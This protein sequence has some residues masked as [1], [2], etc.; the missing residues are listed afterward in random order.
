M[1]RVN[2][3]GVNHGKG[4]RVPFR[5]AEEAVAGRAGGVVYDRHPLADKAVEQRRFP[6]IGSAYKRNNWFHEDIVL[7]YL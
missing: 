5:I 7:Y 4:A 1:R 6:D 2:A 3:A